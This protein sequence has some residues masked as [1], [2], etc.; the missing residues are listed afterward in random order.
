M[1]NPDIAELIKD[2]TPLTPGQLERLVI[3]LRG[4]DA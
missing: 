1:S 2:W 3:L 4:D